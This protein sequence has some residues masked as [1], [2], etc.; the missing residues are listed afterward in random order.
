MSPFLF[1]SWNRGSNGMRDYRFSS[2]TAP[3][4]VPCFSGGLLAV[5]RS[6]SDIEMSKPLSQITSAEDAF[7]GR[8]T[9]QSS[10][11]RRQSFGRAMPKSACSQAS[12]ST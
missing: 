5:A 7:S 9:V 8:L 4:F 10:L 1:L 3:T 12:P 2:I 11:L 6:R